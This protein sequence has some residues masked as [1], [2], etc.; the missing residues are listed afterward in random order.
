MSWSPDGATIAICAGRLEN[1]R[2]RAELLEIS[3]TDGSEHQIPVPD[4]DYIDDVQWLSDKN[5]LLVTARET[6]GSPFQVWLV[7][8]PNGETRRITQDIENYNSLSL[9]ADSRTLVAEQSISH[10]NIW[11]AS[12]TDTKQEKQLT[13]GRAAND[14]YFGV[15]AMPDGRIVYTSPRSGNTDL[16]IMNA[17]GS[18][19]RQLTDK[20]GENVRPEPSADGNFIFFVSTR[21]GAERIWRIDADGGNAKQLT[22]GDGFQNRPIASPDGNWVYYNWG[23]GINSLIW[24][25]SVEGGKP[26]RVSTNEHAEAFSISPDGKLLVFQQY[27]KGSRTPWQFGVMRTDTG[28]TVRLFDNQMAGRIEWSADSKALVYIESPKFLN[29]WQQ[30]LDGKSPHRITNFDTQQL[31]AFDILP[32]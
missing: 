1:G 27:D 23:Q 19:Q 22:D 18:N 14:G 7:S 26:I 12:L 13:F 32:D 3:L 20:A 29:L 8:Y 25:V 10:Y 6:S 31:R 24:K 5:G 9:T 21:T 15:A 17:D 16:W 30:P 28:E 11:S 4:W 2:K